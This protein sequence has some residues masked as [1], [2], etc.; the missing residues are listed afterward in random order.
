MAPGQ[1]PFD[2]FHVKHPTVSTA[3]QA[4]GAQLPLLE[5]YHAGEEARNQQRAGSQPGRDVHGLAPRM[6]PPITITSYVYIIPSP[7]PYKSVRSRE[8]GAR[9]SLPLPCVTHSG[10]ALTFC[11]DTGSTG[12]PS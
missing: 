12:R 9:L 7:A 3:F 4:P 1:T 11:P 5:L 10:A 8:H 2:G 6:P